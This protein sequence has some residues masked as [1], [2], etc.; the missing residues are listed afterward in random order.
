MPVRGLG[1]SGP[2]KEVAGSVREARMTK[3]VKFPTEVDPFLVQVVA[4]GVAHDLPA[5][6]EEGKTGL[7]KRA[8]LVREKSGFPIIH[9]MFFSP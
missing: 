1:C 7:R 4:V 8:G 2:S 6:I 9:G 5:A 3:D